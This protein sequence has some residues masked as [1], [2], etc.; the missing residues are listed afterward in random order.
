M[1]SVA[2]QP[3]LSAIR[4]DLTRIR[5]ATVRL[6][7]AV[8]R[9]STRA[10]TAATRGPFTTL[11][12][13]TTA[14]ALIAL[15]LGLWQG[16]VELTALALVLLT[17]LIAA[18]AWTLRRAAFAAHIDLD[19]HRIPVGDEVLGRV[20]VR[21]RG[22]RLA[23][24][25]RIELPVGAS[26]D[27][28][29]LPLLARGAEHEQAFAVPGRRRAVVA[30]ARPSPGPAVEQDRGRHRADGDEQHREVAD[31]GGEGLA[32]AHGDRVLEHP[33]LADAGAL[34]HAALR[35]DDGREAGGGGL[36]HPAVVLEGPQARRR[37]LLA[38]HLGEPVRRAVGG[39]QQHPAAVADGVAAPGGEEHL[40]GDDHA[41]PARRGVHDRGGVAGEG[42]AA[43]QLAVEPLEEAAQRDVLA[44]GHPLDLV[45]AVDDAAVRGVDHG[46][47]EEVVGGALDHAD[48]EGG[49][50]LAGQRRQLL[51]LPVHLEAA[52]DADH[53]LGP[54]DEVDGTV[55]VLT[56]GEVALE[57][58][59]LVGVGRPRPLGAAALDDGDVEVRD[60]VG[61]RG[62]PG[63][64][65]EQG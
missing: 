56:G 63:G 33:P 35:G 4:P 61:P 65:R 34:H 45:V 1:S 46:G 58:L 60:A 18:F 9:T 12:A 47:V 30:V 62:H 37:H 5:A 41:E 10:R 38:L 3:R 31:A 39:V 25:D 6:G 28:Y 20:V 48:D 40:P 36:E 43:G 8:A 54:Q 15:T 51:V 7:S 32:L 53:V 27:W 64:E 59:A 13:G 50:E 17:V 44:E 42:V 26:R 22:A 19:T 21:N 16:W 57:D 49:V 52:L 23:V 2:R 11:G 55:D 24:P 14:L 29:P